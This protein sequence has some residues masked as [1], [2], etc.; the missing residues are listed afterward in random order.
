[1]NVLLD[2]VN[3]D[4][5]SMEV[6]SVVAKYYKELYEVKE[7]EIGNDFLN[8]DNQSVPENEWPLLLNEISKSEVKSVIFSATRNKAPGK[9][10]LPSEFI[11]LLL[12]DLVK[13][14]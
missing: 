8:V 5:S 1:M 2:V 9:D 6:F 4:V 3:K 11:V 10:G 12:G 14:L 13:M 7:C